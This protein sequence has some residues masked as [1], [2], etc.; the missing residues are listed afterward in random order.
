MSYSQKKENWGQSPTRNLAKG[1]GDGIFNMFFLRLRLTYLFQQ[2]TIWFGRKFFSKNSL[3]PHLL[4]NIS[5]QPNAGTL[6]YL[7]EQIKVQNKKLDRRKETDA[8]ENL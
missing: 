7:L 6:N 1:L 2:I 4:T 8:M 3:F 5:Q